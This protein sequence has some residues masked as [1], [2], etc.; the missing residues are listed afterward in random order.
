MLS[1]TIKE[2]CLFFLLFI[3]IKNFQVLK[4]LTSEEYANT[5]RAKIL[6]N[7][8]FASADHYGGIYYNKDDHGTAHMSVL[9]A[10]GDAVSVTSTVNL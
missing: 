1:Q 4:D 10:N 5:I 8:T 2:Q 9:A 3:F 6:D 7:T